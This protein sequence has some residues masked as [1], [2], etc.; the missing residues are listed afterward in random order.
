MANVIIVGA[1]VAGATTAWHLARLGHSV[2]LLDRAE[3]PRRKACGEGL[4]PGGVG[5]L[6]DM[7]ILA[8]LLPR[9]RVLTALRLDAYGA[10]AQVDLAPEG[11]SLGIKREILDEALLRHAEAAGAQVSFGVTALGLLPGQTPGRFAGVE[12]NKGALSAAVVVAADG[13]GSRMRRAGGLH[14]TNSGRR[15]G[16]SAHFGAGSLPEPAI[17]IHFERNYEVYVTPVGG[18]V[19]NVA[20]LCEAEL[21]RQLG[22]RLKAKFEELVRAGAPML[23][24]GQR[25]DEPL[26]AGPFPSR[27][28]RAWTGNLVL[29]G[30]AAGFYDGVTGEGM[31]IALVAAENCAQA[32]HA[33][34]TDGDGRRFDAYERRLSEL[35]KPSI[36]LGRL[37]LALAA[38]PILGRRALMN[39]SRHPEVFAKLVAISQGRAKL[40]SL[41]PRDAVALIS[42]L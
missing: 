21:A 23:Q 36:M 39:L 7:G 42:G 22:G 5:I 28:K 19:V 30:D 29:A 25:L 15:Y 20:L 6:K 35:Q 10:S 8:E 26:V 13:L 16:V 38:R 34:L 4:L 41:R 14:L 40:R 12:T 18:G 32:V 37:C 31:S 33:F 2:H 9:S 24:G 27:A 1:S 11:H 3:F 17:Q